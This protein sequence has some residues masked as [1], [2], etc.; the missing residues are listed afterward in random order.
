METLENFK[1]EF[2][3]APLALEDFASEATDV[4]ELKDVA[5]AY[6]EAKRDFEQLLNE[7]GVEIG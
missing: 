4:P 2:S 3:G 6:L 1:E 7:V 5:I